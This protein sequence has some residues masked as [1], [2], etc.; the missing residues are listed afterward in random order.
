VI[1]RRGFAGWLAGLAAALSVQRVASAADPMRARVE[2]AVAGRAT[3]VDVET[4]DKTVEVKL[5]LPAA[6]DG[7]PI[8]GW[9]FCLLEHVDGLEVEIEGLVGSLEHHAFW[10]GKTIA[11]V[12]EGGTVG[13]QRVQD[14][15][16]NIEVGTPCYVR[17]DKRPYICVRHG[18]PD[19][20]GVR[21]VGFA[22][23]G[24]DTL[25]PVGSELRM[26][27]WE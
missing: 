17:G 15:L 9:S 12:L 24:Q 25:A 21:F 6:I 13:F 10:Y 3:I 1:T 5:S 23:G 27:P 4:T 7:T 8:Y 22:R 11:T 19:D 14:G 16:H 18:K 26:D 20:L 2:K